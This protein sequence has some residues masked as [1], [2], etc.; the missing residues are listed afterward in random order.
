MPFGPARVAP[1]RGAGTRR[2]PRWSRTAVLCAVVAAYLVA[3]YQ[4]F[5][6]EPPWI[7]NTIEVTDTGGLRF[8]GTSVARTDG[9]PA[10]VAPAVAGGRFTAVVEARTGDA[11][12][13][14][15]ARLVTVSADPG[16]ANLTLG[17]ENDDLY[18]RLRR[19]GSTGVGGSTIVV[20]DVFADDRWRTL[21]LRVG[22]G[23]VTV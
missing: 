22:G 15:P 19:D 12:Q 14:G 5:R 17:Q 13:H 20:D 1:G 11:D 4:P 8:D 7:V 18:V 16:R 10:W 3:A 2:P 23:T 21:V 6:L 9:P